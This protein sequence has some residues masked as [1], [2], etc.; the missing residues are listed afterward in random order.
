MIPLTNS[1]LSSTATG[2]VPSVAGGLQFTYGRT[3]DAA[4]GTRVVILADGN[5]TR[6][7]DYRRKPS[8]P[9]LHRC[10]FLPIT[11]FCYLAQSDSHPLLRPRMLYNG[12]HFCSDSSHVLLPS[13]AS[14]PTPCGLWPAAAYSFNEF[15]S[16]LN[17]VPFGIFSLACAILLMAIFGDD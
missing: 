4:T 1:R 16:T 6:R 12:T 17:G 7:N 2:T 3:E 14:R 5:C 10:A 9:P 11:V 13:T 8:C 15:L